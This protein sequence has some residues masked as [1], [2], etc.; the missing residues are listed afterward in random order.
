MTDPILD[1]QGADTNA[2]QLKHRL[3][4]LPEAAQ[5]R[6]ARAAK[7]TWE[8]ERQ[9]L[10][11]RLDAL[12]SEVAKDEAESAN[13]D[14]HRARLNQQLR[15]IIAPREAE[16]LQ[17]EIQTLSERRSALDDAELA[18]LEEQVTLEGELLAI[19]EQQDA[20]DTA[21]DAAAVLVGAAEV[22][23]SVQLGELATAVVSM[24]STIDS[25]IL[26]R[27]DS[28][29]KHHLVAAARLVGHLCEGCRIDLSAL[30]VH[31]VKLAVAEGELGECPQCGRLLFLA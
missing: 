14:K 26:D 22:G 31:E 12:A 27:Y 7:A 25:A 1:L 10:H 23:I 20:I 16:A 11:G 19:L 9:H 5:L 21:V 2:D 17:H 6:A 30:E 28:L 13:I 8:S 24:R 15:T 4:H 18:A 29:R 3:N